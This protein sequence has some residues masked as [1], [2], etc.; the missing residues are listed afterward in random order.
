M[1][2]VFAISHFLFFGVLFWKYKTLGGLPDTRPWFLETR[3]PLKNQ[4][5]ESVWLISFNDILNPVLEI[6]QWHYF[7]KAVLMSMVTKFIV[8]EL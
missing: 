3:I 6:F 8:Y 2:D 7:F 5:L 1:C 4:V